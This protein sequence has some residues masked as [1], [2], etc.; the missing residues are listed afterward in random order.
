M[1][2]E[3]VGSGNAVE[4]YCIIKNL[5]KRTTAKGSDYLDMIIADNDG[6]INAKLWDYK[7]TDENKF[8]K[9]DFVKVRGSIVTFNEIKQLRVDRIRLVTPLDGVDLSQYIPS[10]VLEGDVM[11][12][13]IE[14]VVCEFEDDELKALVTS[15]LKKYEDKLLYWPAAKSLH[16]AIRG[17]LLMHT[18]SLLRLCQGAVKIYPFVNADLLYTGAILHDI[19]KVNEID[20]TQHGMVGDYTVKGNLLGHL[21]MGCMEV[22][23][24]GKKEGISDET[25]M[26]VEHMLIS[27]HGKPEFGAAK[28]PLTLEAEILS[29]IDNFDAKIYEIHS[30][31][32]SVKPGE[33]TQKLWALDNR[34]FYNHGRGKEGECNLCETTK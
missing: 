7:E 20:S 10:A 9:R 28:L 17:G 2:F 16:H 29:E 18:L 21:V 11:L 34:A 19:S 30:A 13:E 22:E 6:E 33:Y 26:L 14:K 25:L 15:L 31:L 27:H 8:Q 1:N 32:E 5:E 4:G 23:E 3:P 12:K 24:T